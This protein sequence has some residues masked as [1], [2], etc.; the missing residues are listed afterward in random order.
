[1]SQVDDLVREI[2]GVAS[3]VKSRFAVC[4]CVDSETSNKDAADKVEQKMVTQIAKK[5]GF[6]ASVD[7]AAST[8]LYSSIER[9][10]LQLSSR[11]RLVQ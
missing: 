9:S 2:T 4:S 1:M 10:G 11:Q 6:L 7:A 3:A 8:Q 5:I